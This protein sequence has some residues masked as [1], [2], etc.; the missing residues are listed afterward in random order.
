[1]LEAGIFALLSGM[2]GVTAICGTRI[3]PLLLPTDETLPAITW[4]IVSS[5]PRPTFLSSGFVRTRIQ[6]DCWGDVYADAAN[7]RAAL[8]GALNGYVG[9]LSNGL[10]VSNVDRVQS[11]DFYHRDA[12]QYRL[13]VEFVFYHI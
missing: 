3:F 12:M 7:L 1:M 8:I 13:A 4:H 2:S 10:R 11:I 9:T 6:F 5:V